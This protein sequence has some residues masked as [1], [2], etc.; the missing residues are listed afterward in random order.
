MTRLTIGV[1]ADDC[2][3]AADVA[4]L[5]ADEGLEVAVEFGEVT[6]PPPGD[7]D[8]LVIGLKTRTAPRADAVA[9]SL[10]AAARLAAAGA[11]RLYFKYCS[12]FD[13]TE[14]GNIGPVLDALTD[15]VGAAVVVVC[16]AYPAQGRTVQGRQ[17]LVHGVPLAETSMAQHP[18]TPMRDSDVVR[19]LARQTSLPVG[20][21][22][23][24]IVRAGPAA[25]R[26]A[27]ADHAG[28]GRR[29][30][31]VDATTQGDIEA[32]AAAIVDAPLASGGAALAAALGTAATQPRPGLRRAALPDGPVAVLAGSCSEA[33]LAQVTEMAA[34]ASTRVITADELAD[35]AATVE[36]I[37]GWSLARVLAGPI[38]IQ[39]TAA[40][41][42]LAAT[43]QR[44]GREGAAAAVETILGRVAAGLAA[45]G[46]RRI[47]VAG[48]DTAG[49]VVEALRPATYRVAASIEPGIPWLVGEGDRPLAI[50]LKSGNFGR[51]DL[52]RTAIGQAA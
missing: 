46:V 25:V 39:S 49:A 18:L 47:V 5:F 23:G 36:A 28:A 31:V 29:Y 40:P 16:P 7:A 52:F 33:T 32:I 12:T 22:G 38:L 4:S 11:Q 19:L 3:G 50:A 44:F 45:N 51:P 13:S 20:A 24:G 14:T 10:V 48:G 35:P 37:L 30:A 34:W 15:H 41:A 42:E 21:I 2:T 17:L 43:Q 26:A 9:R 27:L 1:I 8:A 6:S